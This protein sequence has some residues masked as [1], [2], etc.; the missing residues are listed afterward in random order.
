MSLSKQEKE[1][2]AVKIFLNF[3]PNFLPT[4]TEN[5]LTVEDLIKGLDAGYHLTDSESS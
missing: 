5:G 1:R 4:L 3:G 2:N